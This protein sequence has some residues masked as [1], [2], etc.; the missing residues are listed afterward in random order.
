[1]LA[2]ETA[3]VANR[4]LWLM[5]CADAMS[6]AVSLASWIGQRILLMT[7]PLS[8]SGLAYVPWHVPL[9]SKTPRPLIARIGCNLGR[10]PTGRGFRSLRRL[11]ENF[12]CRPLEVAKAG[13]FLG[14][15]TPVWGF[16]DTQK[17]FG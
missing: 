17:R 14:F 3:P 9:L 11:Q 16:T 4:D 8:I 10:R 7:V 15:E 2:D 6:R 12:F 5:A 1:M 13:N